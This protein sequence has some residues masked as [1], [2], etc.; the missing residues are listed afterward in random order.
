MAVTTSLKGAIKLIVSC[1]H[2]LVVTI[3]KVSLNDRSEQAVRLQ[4]IN[5]KIM[6]IPF[7]AR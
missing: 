3:C 5:K 2:N 4:L 1:C 7:K 6:L